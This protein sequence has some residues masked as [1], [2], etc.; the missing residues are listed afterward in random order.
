MLFL[1][2]L[3]STGAHDV[4]AAGEMWSAMGLITG[5][6]AGWTQDTMAV[7]HT[8]PLVNPSN[9]PVTNGGYATDPA[10]PGRSLFHAVVE[11]AFQHQKDAQLLI[12]GCAFGKPKIIAVKMFPTTT[13]QLPSLPPPPTVPSTDCPNQGVETVTTKEKLWG[14]LKLK[15]QGTILI[16]SGTTI[17]LAKDRNIEI[18]SCVTIKGT[19]NGLDPVPLLFT[20]WPN[21][22][23][24]KDSPGYFETIFRVTGH[25]VRIEGIRFEGPL[26]TS[27][28]TPSPGVLTAITIENAQNV[29]IDNNDFS[30]WNTAIAANLPRMTPS[31]ANLVRI[32]RNY[33]HRNANEKHG[34]GVV[35]GGGDGY[36]AI[37]G[38]LFTHNRHAVAATGGKYRQGYIARYNYVLEGGFTQSIGGY[39]NQHFD[40][41]GEFKGYGGQAGEYFEI[42]SNTIRG[43]QT[44]SV[45]PFEETRS[46]FMLRGKPTIGAGFHGNVVVHDDA[47]EAVR[48]KGGCAPPGPDTMG[49]CSHGV[50]CTSDAAC[51]LSIGPNIY[52]ND[53]SSDF[54]VGDFDGDGRDD[55]FLANGT[56]WWYSSAGYTEWRFLRP[57]NLRIKDLRFGRFDGDARTDVLAVAGGWYLYSGG[58]TGPVRL[59][60]DG[61]RV[62]DCVFGDFNGDG[63]TDA[64]RANGSMWSVALGAK[65]PWIPKFSSEVTATSLR[66]GDF[67]GNGKDDVLFISGEVA[68]GPIRSKVWSYW[69]Y[70]SEAPT[71]ISATLGNDITSLVVADFDGDGRA[72]VAQTDG[73]GWRWAQSG[74]SAWKS[75]RGPGGQEWYK[76]IHAV[77]LGRFTPDRRVDALRYE[78]IQKADGVGGY[79]Y[80]E[81]GKFAIWDGTQDAFRSWSPDLQEMR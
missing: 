22:N 37:E 80:P 79:I 62:I 16:P 58:V 33:F 28:R 69:Q 77:L 43:E 17:D 3:L 24:E 21:E 2:G 65:G 53:T 61:S 68:V 67:N 73:N 35:L 36:V 11:K 34:Y 50:N 51:N 66:V 71:K 23:D 12:A 63:I 60:D 8:A 52:N 41:H 59:R 48:L 75:L 30:F 49:R 32:T 6:E 15:F 78:R 55:V 20:K 18:A 56:A 39:W 74:A 81:T 1:T 76:D 29:V 27:D 26:H 45:P 31:Q 9:C 4:L 7:E 70:D 40:V 57:S 54:A 64:L 38:N 5:F 47:G 14:L 72:D 19:R 46:A 42:A 25:D 13:R 10:D 44:Y